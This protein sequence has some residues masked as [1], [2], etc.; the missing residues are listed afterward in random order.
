MRALNPTS[1][2]GMNLET[3]S[4]RRRKATRRREHVLVACSVLALIVA[5]VA[6]SVIEWGARN[7]NETRTNVPVATIAER[8]FEPI[9]PA[10][11]WRQFAVLE[12]GSLFM[13]EM[14]LPGFELRYDRLPVVRL[15][16]AEMRGKLPPA[17]WVKLEQPGNTVLLLETELGVFV[18]NLEEVSPG[19]VSRCRMDPYSFGTPS[20]K[21]A[22]LDVR[23]LKVKAL[24]VL[25]NAQVRG[26][27][28]PGWI[29]LAPPSEIPGELPVLA[30]R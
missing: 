10:E 22:E 4:M 13:A 29:A 24:W 2:R 26:Q 12:G 30:A 25:Q 14:K 20:G 5:F 1:F 15:D 8:Q 17:I 23:T 11:Q 21:P 16:G 6:M 28:V 7:I 27:Q 19:F 3:P 9:V 18:K